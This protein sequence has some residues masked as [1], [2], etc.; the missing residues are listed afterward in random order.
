MYVIVRFGL[1]VQ[2]YNFFAISFANSGII[3]I[4]AIRKRN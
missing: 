1:R 4:F 3:R 2:R